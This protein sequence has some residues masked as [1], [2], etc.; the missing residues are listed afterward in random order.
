MRISEHSWRAE[1][2]AMVDDWMFVFSGID[3]EA[4]KAMPGV[5]FF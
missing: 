5:G 4:D 3:V 1:G 2:H